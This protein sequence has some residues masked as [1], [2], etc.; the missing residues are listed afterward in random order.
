MAEA[1]LEEV[2]HLSHGSPSPEPKMEVVESDRP[3]H[4]AEDGLVRP[5]RAGGELNK[6]RLPGTPPDPVVT[7]E[8][9]VA[10]LAAG[11]RTEARRLLSVAARQV[12]EQAEVWEEL[13]GYIDQGD[14]RSFFDVVE[15]DPEAAERWVSG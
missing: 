10:A 14:N 4:R 2:L 7:L 3:G 11:E 9:T 5:A 15:R 1:A 8:R 6:Q 12:R 13:L